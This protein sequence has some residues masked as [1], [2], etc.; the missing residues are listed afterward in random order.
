MKSGRYAAGTAV[1]AFQKTGSGRWRYRVFS[2][3]EGDIKPKSFF[4]GFP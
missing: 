2:L 3:D 1:T 4:P